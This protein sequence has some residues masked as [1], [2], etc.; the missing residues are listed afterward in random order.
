MSESAPA[1]TELS[2][3]PFIIVRI[4]ANHVHTIEALATTSADSLDHTTLH[5][6]YENAIN[7]ACTLYSSK[8]LTNQFAILVTETEDLMVEYDATIADH[9]TL[10]TRVMK[11]EAQLMQTLA[12]MTATTNSSPASHKGQTDPETFTGGIIASWG[13]L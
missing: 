8:N 3:L 11:L 7:L 6:S 12:L 4:I 9:N 5:T 10:T 1:T 2:P 13:L